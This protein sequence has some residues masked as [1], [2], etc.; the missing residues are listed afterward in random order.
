MTSLFYFGSLYKSFHCI[1][2]DTF[3][4]FSYPRSNLLSYLWT[5]DISLQTLPMRAIQFCCSLRIQELFTE[6]Y[7]C[8]IWGQI[9]ISIPGLCLGCLAGLVDSEAQVVFFVVAKIGKRRK[10]RVHKNTFPNHRSLCNTFYCRVARLKPLNWVGQTFQCNTLDMF[11]SVYRQASHN[12]GHS[13]CS[14]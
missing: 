5:T 9:S 11:A 8:N 1:F 6:I 7:N 14:L 13:C 10:T 4:V 3:Q 2:A 12:I